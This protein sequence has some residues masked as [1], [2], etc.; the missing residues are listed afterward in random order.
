MM[1]KRLCWFLAAVSLCFY[2][3][4]MLVGAEE[5]EE[6]GIQIDTS[7]DETYGAFT[8][9]INDT[10]GVTITSCDTAST[11]NEIPAEIE[12]LQVTEIGNAAFMGCN[13]LT[14]I[15]VPK[16]VVSIGESAF[17]N[18]SMLCDVTLPEGLASL[19]KGAFESCTMLSEVHLPNTLTELP[20]AA[21]YNCSYLP[22]IVLPDSVSSIGNEAFYSCTAMTAVT[23][24]AQ[25][26]SIGAYAFQNCQQLTSIAI[27]AS[28]TEIGTYAL[29]GC[30]SMTAI[31]V[32]ENNTVF[33]STDGV[34]FSADKTRLIRYPQAKADAV[35]EIPDS[36]TTLADWSFIGATNLEEIDLNQV[37]EIGEDCFYYCISLL[38]IKVPEGVT[39]LDGAVF[40]YCTEMRS[41]V[42]P[43]TL[44][45]IGDNCFYSCPSLSDVQMPEGVTE[46]GDSCF[47]N[48]I[49]L[50]KLTLPDSIETIGEKAIGYY[51]PSDNSGE[52]RMAQLDVKSGSPAVKRY[53]RQLRTGNAVGWV[54]GGI[55]IVLAA[56]GIVILIL[57]HRSRN[58]IRP[59]TRQAGVQQNTKKKK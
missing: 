1:R 23:L 37:E 54:I 8:Y 51:M 36:C 5:T 42:L 33:S 34:L 35:Y 19:G 32:D 45:R 21:F 24:P 16:G 7:G 28:C 10:G 46:L 41:V 55:A 2:C 56:A 50:Q 4:G 30:Q 17:A 43:T 52:Q 48:C 29:D 9:R 47:Y 31:T 27:P 13:F 26:Q 58:R 38:E 53:L 20:E 15:T 22:S 39:V 57:V 6:S 40:G 14:S 49:A 25:L 3:L 12:G 11:E 44:R 59:T 18:C